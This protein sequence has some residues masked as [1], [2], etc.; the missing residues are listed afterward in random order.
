MTQAIITRTAA[1]FRQQVQIEDSV[2]ARQARIGSGSLTTQLFNNGLRR[3]VQLGLRP[4]Q[5]PWVGA[6]RPELRT[7]PS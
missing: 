1:A 3:P 7:E 4:R 2:L 5:G 6:G